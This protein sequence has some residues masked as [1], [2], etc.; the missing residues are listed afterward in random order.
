MFINGLDDYTIDERGDVGS[1]VR[2]AC[3]QGLSSFIEDILSLTGVD[4]EVY[5]P[6]AKY[7]CALA[8]ILKQ[9]VERLDNVRNE[10]GTCFLRIMR[11][12][13][14]TSS[15]SA[16]SLP[17]LELLQELFAEE[18]VGPSRV[19]WLASDSP[20]NEVVGWSDGTWL[21]PRAVRLLDIV[22]YRQAVLKGFILSM[23]SKTDSTVSVLSTHAYEVC[24]HKH[25]ISNG[26]RQQAWQPMPSRCPCA[27]VKG[28]V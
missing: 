4:L 9:G 3:V 27:R 12:P 28:M 2:I 16:W 13:M 15:G 24:I 5:L 7:H 14:A 21:F 1:W 18:N 22:E 23:S 10:A 20:N 8:G 26:Q 25:S 11:L 6:L 17:G 19:P